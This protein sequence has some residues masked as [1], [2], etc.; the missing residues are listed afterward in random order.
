MTCLS[1]RNALATGSVFSALAAIGLLSP[2]GAWAAD[3]NPFTATSLDEALKLMGATPTA[4][5]EI[6]LSS[7]DIAENGAV[8]QVGVQSQLP[9]TQ[10]I[11]LLVEKN[12]NPLAASFTL[13]EGTAGFVQTR[14]K[15][16]QTTAVWALVKAD[17]RWY[18]A[19][20]ESKV[21]LGGCG[22]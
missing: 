10:E 5:G 1:R 17:G 20:R 11:H 4:S 21:T 13:P 15:M 12:A 19:T 3:A 22:G 8:V 16:G 2:R 14:L 6:T 18:S 9:K 7:P